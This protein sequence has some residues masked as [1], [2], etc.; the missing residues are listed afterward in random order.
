MVEWY[1]QIYSDG[2][3]KHTLDLVKDKVEK[4]KIQF[5]VFLVTLAS[6]PNN[7]LDVIPVNELLFPY[8]QRRTTFVLGVASSRKQA[9]LMA[10]SIVAKVYEE[11]GD[12]QI[13]EWCQQADTNVE[14]E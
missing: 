10:A 6:N 4:Q 2:I 14:M 9:K 5:P 1:A 13:R 3:T 8:Y 12:F 7:L 11:T